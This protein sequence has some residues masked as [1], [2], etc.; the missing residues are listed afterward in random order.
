MSKRRKS[1]EYLEERGVYAGVRAI[2]FFICRRSGNKADL[3]GIHGIENRLGYYNMEFGIIEWVDCC[4]DSYLYRE[5][6]NEE[7][8]ENND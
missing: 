3:D 4:A 7:K 8:T 1:L 5:F 2:F 6:D